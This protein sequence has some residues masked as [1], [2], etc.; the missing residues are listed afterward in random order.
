MTEAPLMCAYGVTETGA[1]S[2]VAG[3]VTRA[4]KKGNDWVLNGFVSLEINGIDQRCGSRMQA[5][6]TGSLCLPELTLLLLLARL[7]L[8]LS[9]YVS[10]FK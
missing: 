3:L 2:D 10:T 7:S 8:G 4:E 5:M 1:G 6:Q 9:W